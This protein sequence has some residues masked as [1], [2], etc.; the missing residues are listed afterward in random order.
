MQI[1]DVK[2]QYNSGVV[3]VAW[4]ANDYSGSH[5]RFYV[6]LYISGSWCS[7]CTYISKQMCVTVSYITLFGQYSLIYNSKTINTSN[8][9]DLDLKHCI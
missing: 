3:V 5:I 4:N 6:N 2:A 7:T 1:T 8:I 9:S